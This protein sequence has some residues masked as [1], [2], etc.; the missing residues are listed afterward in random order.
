MN[1]EIGYIIKKK[2]SLDLLMT[3]ILVRGKYV[4]CSYMNSCIRNVKNFDLLKSD[5]CIDGF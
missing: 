2:T 1:K 4:C 5:V 3:D